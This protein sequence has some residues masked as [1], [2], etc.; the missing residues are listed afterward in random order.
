MLQSP[1]QK[2]R[3]AYAHSTLYQLDQAC[4]Q[5]VS[6]YV[7]LLQRVPAMGAAQQAEKKLE[8]RGKK[9]KSQPW[10]FPP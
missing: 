8:K 3:K 1:L 9:K 2:G 4:S 10:T 7:L 5:Y 6:N